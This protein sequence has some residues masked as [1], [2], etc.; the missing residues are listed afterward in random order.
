VLDAL[1]NLLRLR[2]ARPA[3][4]DTR[5]DVSDEQIAKLLRIL[6]NEPPQPY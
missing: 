3:Y 1:L 5:Q 6:S 4:G 2:L